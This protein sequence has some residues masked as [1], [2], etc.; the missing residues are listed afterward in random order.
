MTS[1]ERDRHCKRW[2]RAQ[3]WA[4]SPVALLALC[5]SQAVGNS[6]WDQRGDSCGARLTERCDAPQPEQERGSVDRVT[7]TE[8]VLWHVIA[9]GGGGRSMVLMEY[10][11]S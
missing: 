8:L 2:Q 6:K 3:S 7:L 10:G 9:K 11:K 4:A 5:L 1:P